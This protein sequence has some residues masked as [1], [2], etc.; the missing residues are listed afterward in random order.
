MDEMI[1]NM[2]KKMNENQYLSNV[3]VPILDDFKIIPNEG[4]LFTAVSGVNYIEQFLTDGILKEGDNFEKHVKNV[5]R[6][7]EKTMMEAGLEDVEN[8][9]HYL[10]DYKTKDFH[11][12]V[13][14][15]DNI[16]KGK[17][18]R[19]FNIFFLDPDYNSFYQLSLATSPYPVEEMD[20]VREAL[21]VNVI[22]TINNLMDNITH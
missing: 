6:D 14:V 10:K 3:H 9:I 5:M 21:T 15:Q 12:K 13:Y 8:N 19:Q 16:G 22:T 1:M 18:I 11:F 17:I 7:I 2:T 4:T 20:Y